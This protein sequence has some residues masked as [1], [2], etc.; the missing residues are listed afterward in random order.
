MLLLALLF[1]CQ[2]RDT[3]VIK[4]KD[5][6]LTDFVDFLDSDD[7]VLNKSGGTR[8]VVK[9]EPG[10]A[11]GAYRLEQKG[12]RTLVHASDPLG[13]QYGV[14]HALELHGFRFY[15]PERT[16]QPDEIAPLD[17]VPEGLYEPEMARRGLHMHTLHPI[18]GMWDFWVPNSSDRPQRIIDWTIKNRGNHIQWV[19]LDNIDGRDL[20]AQQ[21][22]RD[23]TRG[24]VDYAHE[25]GVTT[26][27]GVQLFGGANLQFA[28]DLV[29]ANAWNAAQAAERLDV[30]FGDID[31]DVLSLSFGEFS[32]TEPEN[33]VSAASEASAFMEQEY[34][35]VERVATIHVGDDLRVEYQG[36][37]MIYYFLATFV[38]PPLKPWIHTVM[39]YNLF[40]DAGLAYHHEEFD[41]HREYLVEAIAA[42]EPVGYH[43][44]SAYWV[45]FDINVPTYLPLYIRSRWLDMHEA[46]GID[47]HVLFSSG[48]EWGYWQNDYA[49]LRMNYTVPDDHGDVVRQ[50]FPEPELADVV[51]ELS[52]LQARYLIDQRLA[53]Y[54]AGR[55]AVI[56]IGGSR[57][58]IAQPDRPELGETPPDGVLDGLDAMADESEALLDRLQGDSWWVDEV[59]D[60]IEIDVHRARFARLVFEA[61]M[62][63]D[64]DMLAD[65]EAE[66]AKA[67]LVVDRRHDDLHYGDAERLLR[68]EQNP[69]LY[70]FGYLEKAETMCFWE[71]EL[72]Q[73]RNVINGTTERE[74][75]CI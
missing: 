58:I 16:R 33:F 4:S 49:T 28:Y 44:E 62:R 3:L 37:E 74:P 35:Q 2:S 17:N 68:L 36:E 43:P 39:Y 19:G 60:G 14:A 38:E 1:G 70:Q 12:K 71:R 52:E 72:V 15:H 31:F 41:M 21:E 53:A 40:E 32:G 18:E 29:D 69:T 5:V 45:A 46:P 26:G 47:D 67:R 64:A 50:M 51:I 73:A 63:G 27:L 22:W 57:G 59:R 42:D 6:D 25:R 55:E 7:V 34:P 56:D 11:E 9:D 66:L 48:W 65:A 54:M 13:V 10:L 23:H 61:S 75:P 30:V 24:I 8:V 20:V